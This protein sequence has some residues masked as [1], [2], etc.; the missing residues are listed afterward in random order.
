M[1][2]NVEAELAKVPRRCRKAQSSISPGF[3]MCVRFIK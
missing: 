3:D 2:Y 1:P